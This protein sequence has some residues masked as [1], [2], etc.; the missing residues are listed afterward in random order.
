MKIQFQMTAWIISIISLFL[1][2]CSID[3]AA[4]ALSAA[5]PEFT[6]DHQ[7]H[8]E[9][10]RRAFKAK[11]D[12]WYQF[13][14]DIA[15]GWIPDY[16]PFLAWYPGGGSGHVTHI[17]N[18]RCFFNQYVP[19]TPPN[20]S[21]VAAPVTMF[22]NAELI[23]EGYPGVPETVS[24]IVYDTKGNSVWFQAVGGTSVTQTSPTHIA[25]TG[26]LNVI[27]G[28]GKFEAASGEV[29][30]SGYF[31]PQDQQDAGFDLNGWISY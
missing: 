11:L 31:N 27:G 5:E 21:S 29:A 2:G 18:A 7:S 19:F 25:F 26:T 28:T 6:L 9:A 20:F 24:S 4:P 30:I 15:N 23:A 22:F 16:G 8:K 14:P 1:S 13:V 3:S 10:G 12:T 17:G